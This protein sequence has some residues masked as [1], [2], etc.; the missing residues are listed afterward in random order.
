[1]DLES[2]PVVTVVSSESVSA[3]SPSSFTS[4]TDEIV[5]VVLSCSVPQV[6]VDG[7]S[8]PLGAEWLSQHS[9]EDH[10]G[11]VV[12]TGVVVTDVAP[13][14]VSVNLH[15]S[16][17]GSA[18]S[19]S[20]GGNQSDQTLVGSVTAARWLSGSTTEVVPFVVADLLNT[21]LVV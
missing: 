7:L 18:D 12:R 3:V 6:G 4:V 1:L 13:F 10:T 11:I 16:C 5:K 15:K 2:F 17:G 9:A 21:I 19:S 14:F 8:S 20:V